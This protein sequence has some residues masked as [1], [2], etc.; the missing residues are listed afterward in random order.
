MTRLTLRLDFGEH[1]QIGPGKVRLLELIDEHGSISAA[2][3]IMGMSYKRA[4]TL[5]ETLNRMF[6]DPVIVARAGGPGGGRAA[7]TQTGQMVVQ[8][9]R[10]IEDRAG[11]AA[12]AELALIQQ[13]LAPAG[14]AAIS[15]KP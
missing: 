11:L 12:Q 13:R 3:R 1:L 6:T 9:Y 8:A 5:V 15:D 7:L 2:S 4:W 14:H 10:T